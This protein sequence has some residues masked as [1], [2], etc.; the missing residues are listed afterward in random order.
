M[1]PISKLN[2]LYAAKNPEA[3]AMAESVRQQIENFGDYK[4]SWEKAHY[5][6]LV[7]KA[8]RFAEL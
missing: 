1:S 5:L 2:I 3:D 4:H 6:N 7:E 8:K